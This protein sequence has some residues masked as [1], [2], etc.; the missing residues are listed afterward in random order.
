MA[1]SIGIAKGHAHEATGA[2]V[3][4]RVD[5]HHFAGQVEQRATGVT[6][7]D[8]HVGLD[9][10]YVVLVWQAATDGTDDALGNG[11]VKAER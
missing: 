11:V 2:G 6:R 5:P 1:T 9:E 4:L 3:D 10:R 8:R 7:V